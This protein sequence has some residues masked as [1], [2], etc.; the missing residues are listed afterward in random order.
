MNYLWFLPLVALIWILLWA[1]SSARAQEAAVHY[2]PV[3]PPEVTIPKLKAM[4]RAVEHT[5]WDFVGLAGER[6]SYGILEATWKMWS[7]KPFTWASSY[8]PMC[9]DETERVVS[10]HLAYIKGVLRKQGYTH[11]PYS[12]ALF[13]KAGETRFTEHRT[14]FV[15]TEYAKRA[16][17]IYEDV[18]QP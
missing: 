9:V 6:S 10:K 17:N 4:I 18:N 7:L 1:F 16:M 14:R 2:N 12:V 15:D 11:T 3:V 13:W 8:D 5:P